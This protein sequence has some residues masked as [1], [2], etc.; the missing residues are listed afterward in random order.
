MTELVLEWANNLDSLK[1]VVAS[2]SAA[3]YGSPESLPLSEDS[4]LNPLSPYASTKKDMELALQRFA[5]REKRAKKVSFLFLLSFPL[6]LFL[7]PH[8]PSVPCLACDGSCFALFQRLRTET[9]P[10]VSVQRSDLG[11][12]CPSNGGT[13]SHH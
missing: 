9:R 3:V 12:L 1:S 11:L 5:E 4:L 6:F 7:V 13:S 8:F 2:S 10:I